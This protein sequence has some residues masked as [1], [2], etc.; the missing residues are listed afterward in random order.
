MMTGTTAT[1]QAAAGTDIST[2]GKTPSFNPA[3]GAAK[4]QEHQKISLMK[5]SDAFKEVRTIKYALDLSKRKNHIKNESNKK[6]APDADEEL[7]IRFALF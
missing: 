6:D 1:T 4:T 3:G 5:R 7:R 2:T